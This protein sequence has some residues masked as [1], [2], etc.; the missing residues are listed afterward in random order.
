[1]KK[2]QN[3]LYI[4][5][6]K[7]YIHKERETIV[8]EHEQQKLMQL[9]IH[10]IS[11]IFCF[12][13]VMVSPFLLGFCAEKNIGLAFFN[14]YGRF[15]ARMQ[16]KQSGNVLLR[17][18]QYKASEI[19]PGEVARNIVAAK[20]LSSRGVLQRQLRNYGEH[21]ALQNAVRRMKHSLQQARNCSAVSQLRGIEGEAAATYFGVFNDLIRAD[22]NNG[23]CFNGRSRRPPK[24]AVNAM[25][26]FLYSV[27]GQDVSAALQ[28]VG[29]DPQIGFLH[30]DRPGRDSL[31][32][33]IL[34]EFRAWW[35]D[36]LVLTLINR[37]Q[38]DIKGFVVEASGAVQMDDTT[39]KILLA[40]YQERKQEEVDHPFLKEKVPIGLLPH[41]QAQLLASHLRGD[42]E[43]YPPFVAR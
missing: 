21:P 6:Q 30:A 7:T 32:Q 31:A 9:P 33:D 19:S 23:F 18:A 1:M 34:E 29:L 42:L 13:N 16:G 25:L 10:S 20:I 22:S 39:R 43:Q 2:L 14:Q 35:I 8:I 28:G 24:D 17:R 4:T 41:I 40:A 36:R 12:G 3:S 26:S 38:V 37:K 11:S 5:K 15:L 27:L